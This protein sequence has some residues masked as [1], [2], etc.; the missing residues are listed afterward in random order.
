[1]EPNMLGLPKEDTIRFT[2]EVTERKQRIL[3]RSYGYLWICDGFTT[4]SDNHFIAEVDVA[5]VRNRKTLKFEF[6]V[7]R[8]YLGGDTEFIFDAIRKAPSPKN[9]NYELGDQYGFKL[10]NFITK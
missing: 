8:K 7:A 6:D 3:P 5:S 10:Q 9:L 4:T 1:M 2:I